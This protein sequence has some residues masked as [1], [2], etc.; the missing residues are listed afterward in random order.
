LHLL[1]RTHTYR[2]IANA[3]H[4]RCLVDDVYQATRRTTA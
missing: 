4:N 3:I 1:I 2:A